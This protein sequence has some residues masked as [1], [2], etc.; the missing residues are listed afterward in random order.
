MALSLVGGGALP[1]ATCLSWPSI[2]HGLQA[3]ADFGTCCRCCFGFSFTKLPANM[4]VCVSLPK[5]VL[6]S[7]PAV[8]M[9]SPFHFP[10]EL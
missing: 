9:I 1:V 4:C 2:F 8:W 6:K 3:D 5:F 10:G 7:C